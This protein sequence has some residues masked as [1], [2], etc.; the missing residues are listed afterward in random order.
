M[1]FAA[2]RFWSHDKYLS[3][4]CANV[5]IIHDTTI[6]VSRKINHIHLLFKTNV[7]NVIIFP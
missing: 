2:V 5:S 3:V 1:I 6:E 7:I 4:R